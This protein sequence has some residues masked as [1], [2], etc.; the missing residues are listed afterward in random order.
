MTEKGIYKGKKSK[1]LKTP[2]NHRPHLGGCL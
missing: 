2:T 1:I